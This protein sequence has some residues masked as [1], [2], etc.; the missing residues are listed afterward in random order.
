[1]NASP[2]DHRPRF[3][4]VTP[5]FNM[6]DLL[7]CCAAS[8]IDQEGVEVEHII[9]D[10]GS[11]DGTAAWAEKQTGSTFISEPDEGMYDAVNKG[12]NRVRGD[13]VSYLNCDE[14]YLPGTLNKVAEYFRNNPQVDIL[15]GSALVIRPDGK[16]L[17][18]RKAYPTR[19]LYIL[20]DHL[21]VLTC[22]MFMRRSVLDRGL[23]FDTT[24]RSLGDADLV[25]RILRDGFR[26]GYIR[27]YL[28]TF[29]FTGNNL[30]A[31]PVSIAERK[32]LLATAPAWARAV[33]PIVTVYR[34]LQKLCWGAYR[35]GGPIDY[36]IYIPGQ[37]GSRAHLTA[38]HA[39]YRWNIEST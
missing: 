28:A 15:W 37:L 38:D 21:N 25:V 35:F 14:Q 1:M 22:G 20:T 36:S 4:V 23:R 34:R 19:P 24:F 7:P 30:S 16:A 18:H 2:T 27:D 3:S 33:R 13:F 17:A 26:P 39:T 5:S 8:I 29:A 10:G 9:M 6:A 12:W 32:R 31:N 11:T